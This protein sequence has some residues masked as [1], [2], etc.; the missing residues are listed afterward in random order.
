MS[1]HRIP[2]KRWLITFAAI[3]TAG[4]V[5]FMLPS[6]SGHPTLPLLGCGIAVAACIRWGRSM[7]PA[8]LVASIGTDLWT[9]QPLIASIFVGIGA[10]GAAV[11]T[12]QLL[13]SRGFD[14]G[15]AGARDV[16]V[17]ILAATIGMTIV[18]TLGLLGFYLAG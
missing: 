15:F 7:W 8:V 16:P 13:A 9:H 2:A 6:V 1:L 3:F 5:G 17:F 4:A 10:A 14:A 11:A 18:P 12:A